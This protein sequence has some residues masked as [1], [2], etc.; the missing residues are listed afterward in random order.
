MRSASSAYTMPE[1]RLSLACL[2]ELCLRRKNEHEGR[3]CKAHRTPWFMAA[4]DWL[5]RSMRCK[6]VDNVADFVAEHSCQQLSRDGDAKHD[7]T[8]ETLGSAFERSK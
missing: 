2:R 7:G 3:L 4:I 6:P 8:M 1:P 5:C